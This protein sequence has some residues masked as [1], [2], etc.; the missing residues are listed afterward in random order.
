MAYNYIVP[1]YISFQDRYLFA[2]MAY[3]Y[4]VAIWHIVV[5]RYDDIGDEQ[6]QMDL[7]AF[8]GS[9]VLYVL[10]QIVF[11]IIVIVKVRKRRAPEHTWALSYILHVCCRFDICYRRMRIHV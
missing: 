8:I 7:G 6:I 4:L 11:F 1:V 9:V 3:N 5:S 10:I 2:S